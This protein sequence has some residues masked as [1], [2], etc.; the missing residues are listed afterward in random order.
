MNSTFHDKNRSGKQ[1]RERYMN[2]VRFGNGAPKISGWSPE[3]DQLLFHK[4]MNYGAKW[5]EIGK[6]MQ[7]RFAISL[8]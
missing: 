5:V 8:P 2:Y 3:E 7:G 1:C 6:E 4:F